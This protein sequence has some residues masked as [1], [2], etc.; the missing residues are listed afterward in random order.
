MV[1]LS[2]PSPVND[3]EDYLV[4]VDYARIETD[5]NRLC[6]PEQPEF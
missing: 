2:S 3:V 5:E 1:Y 4:T 6:N